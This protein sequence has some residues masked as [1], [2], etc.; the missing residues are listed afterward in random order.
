MFSKSLTV[1]ECSVGQL[2]DLVDFPFSALLSSPNVKRAKGPLRIDTPNKTPLIIHIPK[3]YTL[4]DAWG[5]DFLKA[6]RKAINGTASD[7]L[8]I[9]T[10]DQ[11]PKICSDCTQR[12]FHYMESSSGIEDAGH[13][14]VN[15]KI[16]L[17][18]DR[19]KH[20]KKN[21]PTKS[22]VL[23]VIGTNPR[24]EAICMAPVSNPSQRNLFVTHKKLE[25]SYEQENIRLLQRS[26][27]K[28]SVK[29]RDLPIVQPFANWGFSAGTLTQKKLAKREL[30]ENEVADFIYTLKRDSKEEDVKE[31]I[32]GIGYREKALDDW[33]DSFENEAMASKWST[34]PTRAQDT[35]K[36]I[37][38]NDELEW[39]QKF[40]NLLIN[41]NDV[42]EGWSQIALEPD[43]KEAIV[44]LVHQ[45][46]HTDTQD[47]GILKRSRV[48]GALLY[49][50][51]GSG[52]TH[53]ARVLARESKAI[54]IC[55]SPADI[56]NKYVGETEK[57]IQGLFNLGRMLFPCIIF[58]DEADALFQ[59]R[60]SDDRSW[61]RSRTNQ[62]LHEIDGL[63]K[64]KSSPFVILATNFPR[65]LDHAVLR[66]VPSRIHI[67]LPSPEARQ[68]IFEIC[69][70]D[71]ML[72]PDVG[73]H[74]LVEK[75][76]GYSC[77]DI[78]SVCFQAAL[79][80]DTVVGYNDTRRLLEQRHFE[81]AFQRSAPTVSKMALAEIRTF[82][83]EFDPAALVFMGQEENNIHMPSKPS[84]FRN[85]QPR[86]QGKA[87]LSQ[88][89]GLDLETNS[90][91]HEHSTASS[92]KFED[93]KSQADGAVWVSLRNATNTFL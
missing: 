93:V 49:G 35:I 15:Y 14:Q 28:L 27:R 2:S 33:C 56:E 46:S 53:L 74:N 21:C 66:R 62:F 90:T 85:D 50:P 60:K 55:A 52:K 3:I 7:I 92:R 73:L 1:A 34:F 20:A 45:P 42:E 61:E 63:K 48:G 51:P 36:Q 72:H 79:V 12:D 41:P 32:L 26:I 43:V 29:L 22:E 87:P 31:V 5:T 38:R 78:H 54:M 68:Q 8:I 16:P 11:E 37:E 40:I 69:L 24:K 58:I 17:S 10:T 80:C 81:K 23:W 89:I 67:G 77:S 70:K 88:P 76:R 6:L 82:A 39:E 30:R 65:E 13:V 9:S 86:K 18:R 25:E 19:H 47:Y 59:S 4:Y 64:S 84:Y 83:K 91:R 57:A 44:Q 75:S 71:E